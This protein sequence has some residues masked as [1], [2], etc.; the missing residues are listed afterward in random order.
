MA[1]A[2]CDN[3]GTETSN[4][5]MYGTR[6]FMYGT[7]LKGTRSAPRLCNGSVNMA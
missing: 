3:S 7:L 6:V 1:T 4:G 2:Q 5:G